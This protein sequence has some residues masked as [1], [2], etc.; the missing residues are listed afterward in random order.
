VGANP[1]HNLGHSY[2]LGGQKGA[3]LMVKVGFLPSFS[4]GSSG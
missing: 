3:S 4:Y 2:L 1:G